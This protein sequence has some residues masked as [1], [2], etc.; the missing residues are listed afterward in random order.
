LTLLT[1]LLSTVCL[2]DWVLQPDQPC[3]GERLL[4]MFDRW[5][6][7]AKTFCKKGRFDISKV[8]K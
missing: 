2:Q 5:Q 1:M 8:R 7:L 6:K 4:L 3:S